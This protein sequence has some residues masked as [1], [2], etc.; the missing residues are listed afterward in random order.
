MTNS[1][2]CSERIREGRS[3]HWDWCELL[4]WGWE[5]SRRSSIL[6]ETSR[7]G[8]PG[9]GGREEVVIPGTSVWEP[10]GVFLLSLVLGGMRGA[11]PRAAQ[12]QGASLKP[13][14]GREGS[15]IDGPIWDCPLKEAA[16]SWWD[17]VCLKKCAFTWCWKGFRVEVKA[18]PPRVCP[19]ETWSAQGVAVERGA[20]K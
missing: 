6:V 16:S 12:V 3:G 13:G 5:G 20:G 7:G 4:R 19:A 8:P 11:Q 10:P 18:A 2:K 17:P 1:G 15:Y 9:V 14:E